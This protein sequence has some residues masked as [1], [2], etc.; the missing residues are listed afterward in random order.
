[1]KLTG[2]LLVCAAAGLFTAGALVLNGGPSTTGPAGGPQVGATT[3]IE[4]SD[5]AFAATPVAPGSTVTVASRS[6]HGAASGR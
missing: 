2:S 3:Q 5:L 4:I 6:H 1:M